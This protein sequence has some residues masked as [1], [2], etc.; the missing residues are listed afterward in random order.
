MEQLP[1]REPPY[2][3][4]DLDPPPPSREPESPQRL[5]LVN[6]RWKTWKH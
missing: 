2:D 1:T 3:L 5:D 4:R 6:E